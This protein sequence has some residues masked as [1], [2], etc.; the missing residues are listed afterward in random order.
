M[1]LTSLQVLIY[2]FRTA[3]MSHSQSSGSSSSMSDDEFDDPSMARL[4]LNFMSS[5][6]QD[7]LLSQFGLEDSDH[8]SDTEESALLAPDTDPET[9]DMP[10]GDVIP[11]TPDVFDEPPV[12]P[13]INGSPSAN[14]ETEA[15]HTP[16]PVSTP[17]PTEN[18]ANIVDNQSPSVFIGVISPSILTKL[19]TDAESSSTDSEAL[20]WEE[21]ELG[22]YDPK[23][24]RS[25]P[26]DRAYDQLRTISPNL[27]RSLKAYRQPL[28]CS[29][30]RETIDDKPYPLIYQ[31]FIVC[32]RCLDPDGNPENHSGFTAEKFFQEFEKR[33]R[34]YAQLAARY[35]SPHPFHVLTR[36]SEDCVTSTAQ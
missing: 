20:A 1:A 27:R 35:A 19:E 32:R 17:E 4:F 12:A 2:S 31:P 28:R 9:E 24:D 15:N 3:E 13:A 36:M 30:C 11:V 16:P 14:M 22:P 29:L 18:A 6:P 5:P 34:L 7:P 23:K 26:V 21:A 25:N 10:L 8:E 33:P